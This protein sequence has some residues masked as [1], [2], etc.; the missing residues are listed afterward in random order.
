MA[1]I[2]R[3]IGYL[4]VLMVFAVPFAWLAESD[5]KP[6]PEKK[7]DVIAYLKDE[8]EKQ[9]MVIPKW[10][11]RYGDALLGLIVDVTVWILNR[12]GFFESSG[13][14]SDS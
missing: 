8:M 9:G 14:G 3:V 6:G 5:G 11:E 4:Q 13:D 2:L 7:A 10:L 1:G 12:T